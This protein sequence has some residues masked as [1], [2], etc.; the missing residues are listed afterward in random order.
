MMGQELLNIWSRF[1]KGIVF[2]THDI[3]EA[4]TLSDR[5]IVMT[6]RPG[7]LKSE[8][9]ID[10]ER[11]RNARSVRK[12]PRFHEFVESIWQDIMLP[13]TPTQPSI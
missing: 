5:V 7:K 12:L 4:V 2:V 9:R 13:S 10:I 11:P 6:G 3:E 1:R 8:Y